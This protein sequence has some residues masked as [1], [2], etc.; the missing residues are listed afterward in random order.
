MS[1]ALGIYIGRSF[2]ELSH[3]KS[4]RMAYSLNSID[5][6]FRS[7]LTPIQ[8]ELKP[9]DRIEI[10]T[11]LPWLVT[12]R[13][14]GSAPAFITTNGLESWLDMNLPLTPEH[15]SVELKKTVSALQKELIFGLSERT[16]AA[17][18][19][20]KSPPLEELEFLAEKLK[21]SE[22]THVAVGFL[23]SSK[24]PE[25]E[26]IAAKF[27]RE[28]GFI[29]YASHEYSIDT[30]ERP[31]FWS[32]ILNAY[33]DPFLKEKFDLI[34][35]TLTELEVRPEIIHFAE[36]PLLKFLEGQRQW[37]NLKNQI[38]LDDSKFTVYCGLE[39]FEVLSPAP[40]A[41]RTMSSLGW[42]SAQSFTP[43]TL[44]P[45]P[46]QRL[47]TNFWGALDWSSGRSDSEPGPICLGRGVHPTLMDAM[48]SVYDL[49]QVD[50]LAERMNEKTN[51]K[52]T[53]SFKAYAKSTQSDQTPSEELLKSAGIAW[54]T[55]ISNWSEN[56]KVLL[57]GPLSQMAYSIF[58][59]LKIESSFQL[60]SKNSKDDFYLSEVLQKE[61]GR[62]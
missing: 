15:W 29:V 12:E 38:S 30:E 25:N 8:D 7:L 26:Q 28:K 33:V 21:L 58:K 43:Q 42:V 41:A 22:V 39:D 54:Y 4:K 32:A 24:N 50:G 51:K 47:E 60:S 57:V 44:Q 49:T 37:L 9:V 23:H 11:K 14:I 62:E 31:R 6:Q 3:K 53:D 40:L 19:I 1:N 45:S 34:L 5:S 20:L 35:K 2:I 55:Q 18:D 56:K 61:I 46:F 13:K 16:D 59:Q 52:I 10:R 17:G 36:V 48:A 27:F